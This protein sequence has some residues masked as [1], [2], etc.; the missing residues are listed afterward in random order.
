MSAEP[1]EGT[2]LAGKYRVERELGRGGMGVVYEARH[3]EL[4]QRVAVKLLLPE[5]LGNAEA[6]SR[7]LREARAAARITSDHVVRVFD[8]GT[9]DGGQPF[10]AM[11]YLEGRD[12]GAV[13]AERARLPA[14]EAVGY[15]LEAC[16]A[17]AEA[18]ANG[19]V[20][21]DLKPSNL[22]LMRKRDGSS[23]VKVL[24][25]GIS[26]VS[27]ASGSDGAVTRTA[28]LMGSPLYMSP[29]QM[30][31]SRDV[32]HRSDIWA[33]GIVLYELLAGRVPFVAETLPQICVAVMNHP[34]LPVSSVVSD[35]PAGLSA[36]V[37]RCLAKSP[38]ERYQTIAKLAE[39]LAPYAAGGSGALHRITQSFTGAPAELSPA[40][41]VTAGSG[42]TQGAW[43]KTR[44]PQ[45]RRPL[46]WV[47]AG[48]G[49]LAVG[50]ALYFGMRGRDPAEVAAETAPA[51]TPAAVSSIVPTAAERS[52]APPPPFPTAAPD[53]MSAAPAVSTLPPAAAAPTP[54]VARRAPSPA[55]SVIDTA[56]RRSEPPPTAKSSAPGLGKPGARSRL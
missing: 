50:A 49:F 56:A 37:E 39:A 33:L 21:R 55:S 44:P 12:L 7:F 19:V 23:V 18:H 40:Q 31:S 35:V 30:A 51:E 36:V 1:T 5:A 10:M 6:V 20:H 3:V 16:E 2:L 43:G 32:D 46:V 14:A 45:D 48:F 47:V 13:V 41:A 34:A 28:A 53:V 54:R 24:D 29:E 26:K 27:H 4:D 15:L 42:A 9:V 22:F 17:I 11:E 38:A 52:A 25:F 8:V